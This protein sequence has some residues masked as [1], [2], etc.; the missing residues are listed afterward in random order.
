MKMAWIL[1]HKNT[2]LPDY[3]IHQFASGGLVDFTGPAWVDG[4]KM[5][6]EAFL[7]AE[8]TAMIR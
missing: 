6:P 2:D 5:R 7:S 8:D 3:G 1:S 4:S